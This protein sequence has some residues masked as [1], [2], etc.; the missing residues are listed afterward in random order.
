MKFKNIN[1]SECL[2]CKYPLSSKQPKRLQNAP[3]VFVTGN[4]MVHCYN[5]N[6][7]EMET[8]LT[9]Q[10]GEGYILISRKVWKTERNKVAKKAFSSLSVIGHL[11]LDVIY[12]KHKY[13]QM[14]ARL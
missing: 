13:L 8:R 7:W 6:T 14:N 5:L 2:L 11:V 12:N 9:I 1:G 4:C 3:N 10:A